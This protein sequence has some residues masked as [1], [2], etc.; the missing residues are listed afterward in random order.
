MKVDV[1]TFA[2]GNETREAAF[3]PC[4][5]YRYYLKICW[6]VGQVCNFIGLNPSTATE[7]ADD[8]TIRK[9]KGFARRWGFSGIVMTNLFAF[10]AT[11]PGDMKAH[12]DPI[13]ELNNHFLKQVARGC[14]RSVAAWG[15]DGVHLNRAAVVAALLKKERTLALTCL[16]VTGQ[17]QPAHPL[18]LSYDVPLWTFP[19]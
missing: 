13:G 12:A 19:K 9:C 15:N 11:K 4:G 6:D 18:Y 2:I 17:Q 10:R 8:P 7:R 16:G 14:H 1:L 3:S 5:H